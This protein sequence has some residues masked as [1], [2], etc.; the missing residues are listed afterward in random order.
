MDKC[1][2][3]L[4]GYAV[5]DAS[6]RKTIEHLKIAM[7][8][9]QGQQGGNYE[10]VTEEDLDAM[11]DGTYAPGGSG[12]GG[13]GS[14]G[15]DSGGNTDPGGDNSGGTTDPGGTATIPAGM[16]FA[17]QEMTAPGSDLSAVISFISSVPNEEYSAI[18]AYAS[19]VIKYDGLQVYDPTADYFEMWGNVNHR[20]FVVEEDQL[21]S[22]AFYN[23][24]MENYKLQE[25]GD[26]D[27]GSGEDDAGTA[28]IPAGS[29]FANQTMTNPGVFIEQKIT[30]I[31]SYPNVVYTSVYVTEG[32][33]HYDLSMVYNA[34]NGLDGWADANNRIFIVNEDQEVSEAFYNWFVKNYT[35]QG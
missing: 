28:T 23:W 31:S 24:F 1:F 19:G 2:C 11:F 4:F 9:L 3:H 17:N 32:N 12:S 10:T 30:F 25:S 16:Y 29:Y 26:D 22:E 18:Y 14:G 35:A 33:V 20:M 5:K 13:S 6:A 8:K 15:D 34:Y 21:V 27:T 7:A